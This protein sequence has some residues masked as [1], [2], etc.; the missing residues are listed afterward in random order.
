M[1]ANISLQLTAGILIAAAILAYGQ[2]KDFKSSS[3]A[4]RIK[5]T[6]LGS[7]GGPRPNPVRYGISILV[8]AEGE[9]LLFDCG[10]GAAIRLAQAGIRE[11][12]VDKVFLTH[13]HSDHILS[14]PDLLLAG[15][16]EQGRNTPLR[17]WGPTGTKSMMDN[18]LKAFEFDI[19]I[20]RDVDEK[21]SKE[22]I[23][24][25]ATDIQEGTIYQNR[26]VKVTAFL[27]DHGP[28]KPAFG[29]RVDAGGHSVVMS[30]DTRFSE[31][32][33][34]YASGVDVLI[35]EVGGRDIS[36]FLASGLTR[37]QAESII[38]HHTSPEQTG[39]VFE[40]TKPR[41]AVYAHG[42]NAAAVADARKTYAGPLEVADDL[43]TILVGEKVEFMRPVQ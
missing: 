35:H 15:W 22:G 31:N 3:A 36:G 13:L 21:F 18:L 25:A 39:I 38:D 9:R 30:G 26:G 41:L 40:R 27:V 37:E 29:Y 32:L 5:V 20:R 17:V 23:T 12:E 34:K 11:G 4:V 1:R 28:V 19:H 16:G 8:E 24:V 33:I 7:G 43:S 10:R 6:I 14:I 2:G 42:G